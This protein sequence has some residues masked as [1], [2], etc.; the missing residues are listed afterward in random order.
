[1]LIMML[2]RLFIIAE[3]NQYIYPE[4]TVYIYLET[5]LELSVK[6]IILIGECNFY[7]VWFENIYLEVLEILKG[8]KHNFIGAP[9]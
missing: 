3:F 2:F 4:Y 1:M 7:I 6:Q 5:T 9:W 8:N